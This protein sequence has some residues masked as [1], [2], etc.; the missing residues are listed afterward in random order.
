M[1]VE[2]SAIVLATGGEG[3]VYPRMTLR[4]LSILSG[5]YDLAIGLAMLFAARPMAQ[6]FGAPAPVP[7]LNAELNGVFALAIG[8]G[9]F[10]AARD[11]AGRRG[12]LWIAGVV[13]KGLGAA[14]FLFDHVTEGSPRSFLLFAA[15]DATLALLTAALLMRATKP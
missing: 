5:V 8:I 6:L 3:L 14:V 13:A 4:A 10:W 1:D 2:E 12:Y 7:V 11:L 9:Y 15:S